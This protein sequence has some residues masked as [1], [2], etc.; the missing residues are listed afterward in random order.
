MAT[1]DLTT[2][3]ITGINVTVAGVPTEGQILIH[4]KIDSRP[5]FASNGQGGAMR[6]VGN[7][8]FEGV[9][10]AFGHTPPAIAISGDAKAN[11]GNLA[12]PNNPFALGFWMDKPSGAQHVS[13]ALVMPT[14]LDVYV[15]VSDPSK[16]NC[17]YYDLYFG[18]C[19]NPLVFD[20]ST[21]FA[22]DT[23]T[24]TLYPVQG[25]SAVIT[26]LSGSATTL[27]GIQHMMFSIWNHSEP[28]VVSNSLGVYYRPKSSIDWSLTY[29]QAINEIPITINTICQAQMQVTSGSAWSMSYGIV[30]SHRGVY[31]PD[32]KTLIATD[33]T[34]AKFD[35]GTT[36]GTVTTPGGVQIWP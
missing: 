31:G 36:V 15:P 8:D 32:E 11:S 29:R 13:C 19:A 10:R 17:I 1:I 26:P 3:Q 7:E 12:I 25:L 18:A 35:S 6:A 2:S 16:R 30:E 24:P 22:A 14:R 20:T 9:I 23:S 33:V 21:A 34:I 27:G 28:E 5:I 4:R